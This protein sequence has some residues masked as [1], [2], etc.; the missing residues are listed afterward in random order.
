MWCWLTFFCF[1]VCENQYCF[2]LP[3]WIAYF[4]ETYSITL[5]RAWSDVFEPE[6]TSW[7]YICGPLTYIQ[8]TAYVIY[9]DAMSP[10][11]DNSRK[12]KNRTNWPEVKFLVPEWGIKSTISSS[13][14]LRI[15]PLLTEMKGT[16]KDSHNH[17]YLTEAAEVFTPIKPIKNILESFSAKTEICF[18][19]LQT[20]NKIFLVWL[21]L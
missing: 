15:W 13:Q 8:K 14:G 19:I 16:R 17:N 6:N 9:T 7:K 21:S 20:F 3:I 1:V 11:L 12:Q 4:T 2:C 18:L 10:L 5:L